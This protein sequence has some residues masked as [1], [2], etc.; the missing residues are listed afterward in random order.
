[1]KKYITIDIGG[2]AIKYGIIDQNEEFIHTDDK[3]TDAHK[4]G[5]HIA[6][7]VCEIISTYLESYK[8]IQGVCISTAGMVDTKKGS[9]I[10]SGKQIPD[11]IGINWKE[12]IKE[13]FNLKASVEN[14][15]NCA[16]LSE[17]ISGAGKD[18]KIVLCLTIGTGIG[19]CMVEDG[20]VYHGNSYSGFEVGYLKLKDGDFQDIASTTALVENVKNIKKDYKEEINGKIIFEWIK[21]NDEEVIKQMDKLIDNICIGI[22][23][24]CYTVNPSIVILGGG[25]ME[26]KDYLLPRIKQTMKN[27]LIELIYKNTEFDCAHHKNKAGM[28]GAYYNYINE[29]GK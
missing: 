12:I 20:E 16:G 28:L 18:K 4:G 8:D 26:Q 2:T 23:N 25:I 15:V 5:K 7:T 19:A 6:N 9:I 1:M 13:K 27:H 11:Y 24:I 3:N 10:Y 17:A 14:D 22:A 29:Y 21:Q